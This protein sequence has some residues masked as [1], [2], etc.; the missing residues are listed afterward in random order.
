MQFTNAAVVI[1]II[2]PFASTLFPEPGGL[3]TQVYA[4]F[5]TEIFTM[6]VIQL[7]DPY[8][9]FM[10]HFLAPRAKTQDEMN[11]QMKGLE[12]ELAERYTNMTKIL[13]L[14][15][16]YSSIYP[17]GLFMSAFAL[18]INYFTDRHSLMRTWKRAPPLGPGISEFSRRYFVTL[19]FVAMA[20]MSSYFCKYMWRNDS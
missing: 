14:A 9:H 18:F 16:W 11:L 3:V 5:F 20:F 8:G 17:V 1:T 4:L 12:V 15:L 10:R 13:F 19:S 7:A 6:N 2:T